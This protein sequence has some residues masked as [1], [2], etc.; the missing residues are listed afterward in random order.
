MADLVGL[1]RGQVA[2]RSQHLGDAVVGVVG[3]MRDGPL[4]ID[5]RHDPAV[6]VMDVAQHDAVEVVADGGDPVAPVDLV[7]DRAAREVGDRGESPVGVI[8]VGD[9]PAA[10][11]L[12]EGDAAVAVGG[13]LGGPVRGI[14]E[15]LEVVAAV[16]LERQLAP[17][18]VEHRLEPALVIEAVAAAVEPSQLV[19]V[20]DLLERERGA[21]DRG[22]RVI[23]VA[24]ERDPAA[25]AAADDDALGVG[26][27]GLD[28]PVETARPAGSEQ[29][30][31]GHLP[32]RILGGPAVVGPGERERGLQTTQ[33]EVGH[34][35]VGVPV[36]H[37]DRVADDG[38]GTLDAEGDDPEEV[39]LEPGLLA[40]G[41]RRHRRA[42]AGVALRPMRDGGDDAA[43][44]AVARPS[45]SMRM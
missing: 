25:V 13:H 38:H 22:V 39:K 6:P 9:L 15:R 10:R 26:A 31:R 5:L 35:A 16:V 7:G 2:A 3:E 41:L 11:Q 21:V 28:A 8:S 34:R 23:A 18:P 40:E 1:V 44:T 12:D 43:L 30:V 42:W 36:R 29:G 32:D 20:D 27:E 45:Y 24:Q 37:V 4:A 19:A 14:G 17:G 33:G